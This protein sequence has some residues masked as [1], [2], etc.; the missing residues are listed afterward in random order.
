M[1]QCLPKIAA[2]STKRRPRTTT[3]FWRLH[4]GGRKKALLHGAASS[5]NVQ[6]TERG[7]AKRRRVPRRCY[8]EMPFLLSARAKPTPIFCRGLGPIR[9]RVRVLT[10]EGLC[11]VVWVILWLEARESRDG[12]EIER[13]GRSW[14]LPSHLHGTAIFTKS[15]AV[16]CVL[17]LCFSPGTDGA[18]HLR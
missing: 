15:A 13:S 16:G 5:K 2:A 12:I 11:E 8:F 1:R 10:K 4:G 3:D 18:W 9:S 14:N 17:L 7:W 6:T